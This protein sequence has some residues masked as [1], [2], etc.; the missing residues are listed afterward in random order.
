MLLLIGMRGALLDFTEGFW[1]NKNVKNCE[2]SAS[3]TAGVSTACLYPKPVEESLYDL[4]VNG[5]SCVEIF[6][7]THC[8]L[9]KSFAHGMANILKRFDA[10]C[11]SVH[12]FTSEM[13]QL[14]FFSDYERR[15]TD[16]LE[17]YKYYFRFMNMT[18][19]EV[20]VL[21][22]G[23]SVRSKELFCERYS[24][25]FRVGKENGVTVALE[26]V[27]R[28]QSGSSAYIRD[29]AGMLGDE[30]AFV[31]DT[32]Q[33]IRAGEDP[34][35]FLKAAGSRIAHVHISDAGE[36]GDCLPI[37]KGRFDFRKFF[38]RLNELNPDCNV[39]LELYRNNF[40]PI[41]ELIRSYN[42][43]NKMLEPY[44]REK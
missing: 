38:G 44:G 7:N 41:S 35:S 42:V 5:V 25:L 12:P 36:L 39:I 33:A 30:F 3:M 14:F 20:F 9:K 40:G 13:E 15:M 23:K 26:N 27:S 16:A 2:R 10:K 28:C 18:G 29:V 8:E 37:G 21:H 32:K 34:F 31:L 43:L 11:V 19:A 24:R 1:Y 17:Y 4:T 6:I 22:G